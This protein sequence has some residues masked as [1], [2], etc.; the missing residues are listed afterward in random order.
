VEEGTN[1]KVHPKSNIKMRSSKIILETDGDLKS[2]KSSTVRKVSQ[3]SFSSS[4]GHSHD[5]KVKDPLP[6]GLK[7]QKTKAKNVL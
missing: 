6:P 7:T 2:Q 4:S 3:S 1:L 5:L